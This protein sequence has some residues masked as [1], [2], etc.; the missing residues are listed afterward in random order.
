MT[1]ELT[2]LSLR[3]LTDLTTPLAGTVPATLATLDPAEFTWDDREGDP[4][5]ARLVVQDDD[6]NIAVLAPDVAIVVSINSSEAFTIIVDSLDDDELAPGEESDQQ[7]A[8]ECRML[9]SILD[10]ARVKPVNGYQAS[11][12]ADAR[13]WSAGSLEYD[14]SAWGFA[15]II[16][17]AQSADSEFYVGKPTGWCDPAAAWIG[18]SL[19]DEHQ[20]YIGHWYTIG[21]FTLAADTDLV[22]FMGA[23]NRASVFFDGFSLTEIGT[24]LGFDEVHKVTVR[25]TAGPHRIMAKVS[26]YADGGGDPPFGLG[27][28]LVG[29]PTAFICS[30]F[31]VDEK[32]KLG[33]LVIHT[34]DSWSILEYPDDPPGMSVRQVASIILSEN[35]DEGI[36]SDVTVDGTD[37]LDSNANEWDIYEFITL[38]VGRSLLDALIEWSA[39]Y[40]DFDMPGPTD[41]TLFMW[42]WH[43]RGT[44]SGVVFDVDPDPEVNSLDRLHRTDLASVAD[45]LIVRWA[46]GWIRVPETGGT[47]LGFLKLGKAASIDEATRIATQ[48]LELTG[49]Q[50]TMWSG[51]VDPTGSG[52][53]PY[54]DFGL[55]DTVTVGSHLERAVQISGALTDDGI[56]A[57]VAVR[58]LILHAEDRLALTVKRMSDGTLGGDAKPASPAAPPPPFGAN[59]TG[60]ETTFSR[61]DP[62]EVGEATKDKRLSFS[63][64]LYA[65]AITLKTGGSS[66]TDIEFLVD[67]NDV[68]GGGGTIASAETFVLIPVSYAGINT[69]WVEG[70]KSKLT[71]NVTAVGG[72]ATGLLVEPRFL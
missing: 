10:R 13:T 68:L 27:A 69:V 8:A 62:I 54:L 65:V 5:T 67:G 56:V 38:D 57:K 70:N 43:E 32:G 28:L 48:M 23:D 42:R 21:D 36:L 16:V 22:L 47:K 52:D 26:N 11:P 45:A 55:G 6:D 19:G 25:A 50:Q 63:G 59:P 18:P 12:Y 39:V 14:A 2:E 53:V 30:C 46:G 60:D 31:E 24:Y 51:D 49:A 66:S 17:A 35:D 44:A 40:C 71:V 33:P 64:N 41:K 1:V 15:S 37:L 20:G 9:R 61:K 29:N 72:G 7:T 3:S 58:D 34:D 4:G